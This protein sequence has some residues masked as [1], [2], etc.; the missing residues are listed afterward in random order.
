MTEF[1]AEVVPTPWWR[2]EIDEAV[3]RGDIHVGLL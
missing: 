2:G 1:A 3:A